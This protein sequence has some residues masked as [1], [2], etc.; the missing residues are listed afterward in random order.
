MVSFIQVT[1]TEL[2]ESNEGHLL[3]FCLLFALSKEGNSN[4]LKMED[5][6]LLAL[7][8]NQTEF[9][10]E[11]FSSHPQHQ[12]VSLKIL[13]VVTIFDCYFRNL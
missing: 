9:A 4:A 1:F 10:A 2:S 12:S 13:F 3:A 7:A 11:V 6:L 8:L 5:Q